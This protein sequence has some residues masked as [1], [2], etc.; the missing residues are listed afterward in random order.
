MLQSIAIDSSTDEEEEDE[1]DPRQK[2]RWGNLI[3]NINAIE[4]DI[5]DIKTYAKDS[6]TDL[7]LRLQ[8]DIQDTFKC[9]ICHSTPLKPPVIIA[10]C[11]KKF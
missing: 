8:R 1:S 5:R 7:S 4:N 6:K 11:C 10:K 9:S 2:D 3:E